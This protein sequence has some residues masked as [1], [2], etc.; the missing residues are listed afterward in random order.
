M[1]AGMLTFLFRMDGLFL[2]K[3]S[4]QG[5]FRHWRRTENKKEGGGP[6]KNKG[7]QHFPPL[8]MTSPANVQYQ[9]I[10]DS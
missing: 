1:T 5:R 2:H 8:W 3:L 10:A 6:A 9:D 4:F 7:K